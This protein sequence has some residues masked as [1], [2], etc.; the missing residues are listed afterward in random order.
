MAHT[1]GFLAVIPAKYN[2]HL[3][4]IYFATVSVTISF[5]YVFSPRFAKT[6]NL[7]VALVRYDRFK[8]KIVVV[9]VV[10]AILL[11]FLL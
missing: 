11:W 5:S 4:F 7:I 3:F 2:N 9:V 6:F 1:S 10:V 8:Q